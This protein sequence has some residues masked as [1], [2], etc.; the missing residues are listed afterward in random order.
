MKPKD[1]LI[2]GPANSA[3]ARPYI[4]VTPEGETTAGV[5]SSDISTS[6]GVIEL[7]PLG[8]SHY[9]VQKVTRFTGSGP[10]QVASAAYRNNW[11]QVFGSK[12]PVGQA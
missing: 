2:I 10:A 12:A 11:G 6:A 3:G 8:G 9:E 1:E 7:T 5:L 4:R